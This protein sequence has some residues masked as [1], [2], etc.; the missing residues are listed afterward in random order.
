M[1]RIATNQALKSALRLTA[2]SARSSRSLHTSSARLAHAVAV[3]VPR[4][5]VFPRAYTA[6][7]VSLTCV[8]GLFLNQDPAKCEGGIDEAEAL[9]SKGTG[10]KKK[11]YEFLQKLMETTPN[12]A[13]TLWRFAR[14]CHD[15]ATET[16]DKEAKK[17]F[18]YSGHDAA[19][20]ALE[21]DPNNFACH[22][23]FAITLSSIGDY[24]GTKS[25][26][27]NAFT[28]REHFEKALALKSDDAT[29]S[30]LLGL[31]HFTI[32]DMPWY[33]RKVAATLFASPPESTY[34]AAKECFEAAEAAEPGFYLK[35][36]LMLGKSFDKMGDKASAKLW[37]EKAKSM[38]V[39]NSDD[40][41]AQAE[42]AKL[43]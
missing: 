20:K 38:P 33:T 31:W 16:T 36:A 17:T 1:F 42:A 21:I 10:D 14:A 19:K 39:G 26:I 23:W 13:E 41:Q 37:Y 28:V 25:T 12:D 15:M 27:N 35:N 29:T 24:E 18:V 9:Y 22:K 34:E 5:R 11:V 4:S 32:A 3:S 30:H 6:A 40:V 2:G 7:V 43:C 8:G